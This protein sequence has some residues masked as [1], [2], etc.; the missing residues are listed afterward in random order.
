[1]TDR[2]YGPVEELADP[3]AQEKLDALLREGGLYPEEVKILLGNEAITLQVEP[4]GSAMGCEVRA[5]S[6]SNSYFD[7]SFIERVELGGRTVLRGIRLGNFNR[8]HV[9]PVAWG[10]YT[11]TAP[12]LITFGPAGE[13]AVE[14]SLTLWNV[15]H[16]Q[17]LPEVPTVLG[18]QPDLLTMFTTER[19]ALFRALQYLK[20]R[21][22]N[23]E[24]DPLLQPYLDTL[25]DLLLDPVPKE[26]SE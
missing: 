9:I 1:M 11:R 17:I 16:E 20:R 6:S 8:S 24:A 26:D 2:P 22:V 25:G 5:V 23:V 18:F 13:R 7:E 12:L 15:H 4:T 14:A 3:D 19:R 21:G 10:I